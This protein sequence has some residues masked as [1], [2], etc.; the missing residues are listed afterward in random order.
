MS[1]ITTTL[2]YIHKIPHC[3]GIM[4]ILKESG[5]VDDPDDLFISLVSQVI[6]HRKL[7]S[8]A[9]NGSLRITKRNLDT[10]V[11]FIETQAGLYM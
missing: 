10:A 1:D 2:G 7:W 4:A 11:S 6:Y 5:R 8:T 3:L 9:A